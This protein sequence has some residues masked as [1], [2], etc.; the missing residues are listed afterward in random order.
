MQK[1]IGISL[2]IILFSG[3]AAGGVSRITGSIGKG[4]ATLTFD[5]EYQKNRRETLN[6]K[7]ANIGEG[8]ARG[9]KGIVMV[10]E[11]Y[12]AKH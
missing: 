1:P 10:I 3:G 11:K 9:G 4:L 12:N 8:L 5:N 7:P 2:T 6:K